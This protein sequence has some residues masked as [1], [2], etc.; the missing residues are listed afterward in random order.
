MLVSV[1]WSFSISVVVAGVSGVDTCLYQ[2]VSFNDTIVSDL[3]VSGCLFIE[4]DFA[5]S[6][7]CNVDIEKSEFHNR[8]YLREIQMHSLRIDNSEFQDIGFHSGTMDEVTL[9]G[10]GM[11]SQVDFNKTSINGLYINDSKPG[12]SL[13]FKDCEINNLRIIGGEFESIEFINC[14][15]SF[16]EIGMLRC[17]ELIFKQGYFHRLR[18]SDIDLVEDKTMAQFEGTELVLPQVFS[19]PKLRVDLTR[20]TL[21]SDEFQLLIDLETDQETLGNPQLNYQK[22]R[23]TYYLLAQQFRAAGLKNLELRCE[24]LMREAEYKTMRPGVKKWAFRIWNVYFRGDYGLSPMKILLTAVILWILM[25]VVYLLLGRTNIAWGLIIPT[26]VL[27]TPIDSL[28]PKVVNSPRLLSLTYWIRCFSFSAQ[29]L[30]MPGFTNAGLSYFR[31]VLFGSDVIVPIG[32]GRSLSV[33]QFIAGI[34]LM[35]N[36]IQA[37]VRVIF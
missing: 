10:C 11:Y 34:T 15:A 28:N 32:I 37:F 9:V 6:T 22:V 4:C 20:A 27:N 14:N 26:N 7:W 3:S 18:M 1:F 13:V 29:Q 31:S 8:E 33:V 35:F 12:S 19:D 23:D 2:N 17:R 16:V 36:F 24:Y 25:S 21:N 30:L 5:N